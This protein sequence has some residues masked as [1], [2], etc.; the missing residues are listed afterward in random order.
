MLVESV[1]FSAKTS[2]QRRC[3]STAYSSSRWKGRG[4]HTKVQQSL[5]NT[6]DFLE[7]EPRTIS[8]PSQ[9]QQRSRVTVSRC[10]EACQL[11]HEKRA[12]ISRD[13]N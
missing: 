5:R 11:V 10:A 6:R 12:T 3:L 4:S 9:H 7:P 8:Q 2:L 13:F 1:P